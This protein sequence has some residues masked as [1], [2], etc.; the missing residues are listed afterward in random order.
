MLRLASSLLALSL[1]GCSDDYQAE[2]GTPAD[3][4]YQAACQACHK[5]ATNG[6][7]FQLKTAHANPDFLITKIRH[8][9]LLMP[10]FPKLSDSDL[11]RLSLYL[12]EHSDTV[13]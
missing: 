7:L 3:K 1:T 8:G 5:P 4:M 2:I 6:S 9:S 13:Q 11:N 12:L 10:A